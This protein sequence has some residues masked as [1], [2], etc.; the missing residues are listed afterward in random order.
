VS[1]PFG[2]EAARIILGHPSTAV[3]GIYAEKDELKAIA[4]IAKVG[5]H[6][7]GELEDAGNGR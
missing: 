5:Q 3:T 6:A 4:A 1:R 7:H 2:I